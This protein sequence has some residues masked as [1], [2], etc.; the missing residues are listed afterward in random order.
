MPY[1][2]ILWLWYLPFSRAPASVLE[3]FEINRHRE[4]EIIISLG[5]TLSGK[6]VWETSTGLLACSSSLES[7]KGLEFH[8]SLAC[9][10]GITSAR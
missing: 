8:E 10:V 9:Q 6:R 1:G 7:W 5:H 3:A 2:L 4:R